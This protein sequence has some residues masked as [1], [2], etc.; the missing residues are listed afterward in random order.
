MVQE[1]EY[2]DTVSLFSAVAEI[3]AD[4]VR[5]AVAARG[6][7]TLVLSGGRSPIP[8]YARLAQCSLSWNRVTITLSDERWVPPDSADSNEGMVRRAFCHG[9]SVA[10]HIVGLKTPHDSP[11]VGESACHAAV[12]AVSRPFDVVLLGMGAD[13]HTASLFPGTAG[14][15]EALDPLN[16]TLCKAIIAPT[17]PQPRITLTVSALL[18][19]REVFLLFTGEEKLRVYR[20]AGRPGPIEVLPVRAVLRQ[21]KTPVH[22]FWAV[23]D[24]GQGR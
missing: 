18:D 4:H 7:A 12:A 19:S 1:H 8:V 11:E 15:A 6:S 14:L 21:N 5:E 13:G 10:A 2:A 9:Q 22:V 3:I 23:D 17:V 20:Q 24:D 16:G